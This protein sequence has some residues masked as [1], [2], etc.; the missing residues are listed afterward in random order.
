M[1][2]RPP[3]TGKDDGMVS[4]YSIIEQYPRIVLTRELYLAGWMFGRL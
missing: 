4:N 1:V 3:G 2:T